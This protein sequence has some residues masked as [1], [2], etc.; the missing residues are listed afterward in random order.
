[1]IT[2]KRIAEKIL[3]EVA[4]FFFKEGVGES[5]TGIIMNVMR[6]F[7]YSGGSFALL[8]YLFHVKLDPKLLPVFAVGWY[9][10]NYI[11]GSWHLKKGFYKR[12]QAMSARRGNPFFKELEEKIDE[13]NKKLD[14][15]VTPTDQN[16]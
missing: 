12:L 10:G 2:K 8:E 13:I 3:D 5:L 4:E 16:L 7:V 9:L 6:L 14:Q 11:L 1:M 15:I